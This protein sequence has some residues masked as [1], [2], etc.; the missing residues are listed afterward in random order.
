VVA[1]PNCGTTN[2]DTARFCMSCGTALAA[3]AR[4]VCPKGFATAMRRTE[5]L[6]AG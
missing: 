6:L 1:C 2:P 4:T 5:A 3:P